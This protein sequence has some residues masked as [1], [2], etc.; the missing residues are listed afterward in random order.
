MTDNTEALPPLPPAA[1][2][3][4]CTTEEEAYTADQMRDYAR[5][6][7]AQRQQVP[8][9]PQAAEPQKLA[10]EL[11]RL[12]DILRDCGRLIS[13]SGDAERI[14][15]EAAAALTAARSAQAEPVA[16]CALTPSGKIANFDGKP[17][18]MVGPVG[19]EHHTDPL[20]TAPQAA[21]AQPQEPPRSA[22]LTEEQAIA[23]AAHYDV[24]SAMVRDI[25]NRAHG[26]NTPEEPK[27]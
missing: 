3:N 11:V 17:M 7:L 16:W 6:A 23:I 18:V 8:A 14:M 24:T 12:A 22:P 27:R 13:T 5:A 21:Q 20:Y 10:K 26:I 4:D 1:Y 9:A 15:R 19:N 2:G 25:Y